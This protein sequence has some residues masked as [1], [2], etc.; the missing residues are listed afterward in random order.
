M[1]FPSSLPC[2][3]TQYRWL[4]MSIAFYCSITKELIHLPFISNAIIH[5]LHIYHV[6]EVGGGLLL[7][8]NKALFHFAPGMFRNYRNKVI[9]FI[10][11][12]GLTNKTCKSNENKGFNI[13]NII[14]KNVRPLPP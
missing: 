12:I 10:K 3:D 7:G 2:E 14:S 9:L 6:E 13:Q 1:Y 11:Y 8:E 4:L 5:L